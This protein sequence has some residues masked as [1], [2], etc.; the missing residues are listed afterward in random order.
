MIWVDIGSCNGLLPDGT[1][2][3]PKPMLTFYQPVP[4]FSGKY[5]LCTLNTHLIYHIYIY[6][7][8]YCIIIYNWLSTALRQNNCNLHT[9]H[10]TSC[11]QVDFS[12]ISIFTFLARD[13]IFVLYQRQICILF[14][15]REFF[16]FVWQIIFL[17]GVDNSKFDPKMIK[18]ALLLIFYLFCLLFSLLL[19]RTRQ[20]LSEDTLFAI[21]SEILF[22]LQLHENFLYYPLYGGYFVFQDGRHDR[23]FFFFH[24]FIYLL[25]YYPKWHQL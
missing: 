15:N 2:A 11:L 9:Q 24:F 23:N 14:N 3:S 22:K 13:L 16:I 7:Y 18:F 10:I 4:R 12:K 8:V 19:Y 5:V 1:E 17:G 25:K 6:I 20:D 21:I